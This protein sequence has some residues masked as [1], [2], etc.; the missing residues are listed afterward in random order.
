MRLSDALRHSRERKAVMM[1]AIAEDEELEIPDLDN[2]PVIAS[3]YGIEIQFYVTPMHHVT[4]NKAWSEMSPG[5]RHSLLSSEEWEPIDPKPAM[6][7][8]AEA[9][10]DWSIHE[11]DVEEL[12]PDEEGYYA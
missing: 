3:D 1:A 4:V 2:V 5:D 11:Q 6:L 8:I 7:I 9:A 12:P 10:C